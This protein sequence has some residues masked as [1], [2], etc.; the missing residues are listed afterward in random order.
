MAKPIYRVVVTGDHYTLLS[1]L[2]ITLNDGQTLE[3]MFNDMHDRGYTFVSMAS[4][5]AAF[6]TTAGATCSAWSRS[7]HQPADADAVKQ[8]T[9]GPNSPLAQ[10]TGATAGR[11]WGAS[12]RVWPD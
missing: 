1:G 4:F 9:A 6:D 7:D 11:G 2:T 8:R 3:Q 12:P 5:I 10:M